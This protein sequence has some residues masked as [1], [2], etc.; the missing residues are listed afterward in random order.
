MILTVGISA[1]LEQ[2]ADY[3]CIALLDRDDQR[4]LAQPV[5]MVDL[6]ARLEQFG[7]ALIIATAGGED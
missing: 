2:G 4:G 7:N 6:G 3:R 1:E 5:G